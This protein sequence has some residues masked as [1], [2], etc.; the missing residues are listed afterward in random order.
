MN[1]F[2]DL[3]IVCGDDVFEV[4]KV[5]VCSQSAALK[6]MCVEGGKIINL[7]G[8]KEYISLMIHFLYLGEYS[9]WS[10]EYGGDEDNGRSYDPEILDFIV[11]AEMYALAAEYDI[12]ALAAYAKDRFIQ[13][14]SSKR[15][16]TDFLRCMRFVY[17]A[18]PMPVEYRALQDFALDHIIQHT[19]D[20][21][22]DIEAEVFFYMHCESCPKFVLNLLAKYMKAAIAPNSTSRKRKCSF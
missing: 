9:E 13:S 16:L 6:R 22:G 5:V 21:E 4:H 1:E 11:H 2:S 3:K 7:S 19:A 8:K 17:M 10:V 20:I 14:A 12:P 18:E 15:P